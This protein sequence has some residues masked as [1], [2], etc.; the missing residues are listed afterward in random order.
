M[1][2]LDDGVKAR[3]T[4]CKVCAAVCPVR[5]IRFE[6]DEEGF[7]YPRIDGSKCV[8]CGKCRNVCPQSK[9]P[10]APLADRGGIYAAFSRSPGILENSTSG[11]AFT[12]ISDRILENGGIVFGHTYDGHLNCTCRSAE[13]KEGRGS[14]CGSKYV[15]SDMGTIYAEIGVQAE[16]GRPVLVTG[17]PCQADAVRQFFA[18]GIPENLFLLEI[19]CHGVP[20]PGIF[21]EYLSL[22]ERKKGKRVDGFTFRGKE[23]GWTTPLRKI[24]YEDGACCGELLNADAF[25][26]L[27]LGTDCILRPSCYGCRYAAKERVADISIGD[28]WGIESV[29]P[30]MFNGNKGCSL[31]LVNT[32]KGRRLFGEARKHMAV[33]RVAL[34][35]AA[36]RNLPLRGLSV[37]GIDREQFF[38]DYGR[39]G[40]ERSMRR[41]CF[42]AERTLKGRVKRLVK[43]AVGERNVARLKQILGRTKR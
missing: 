4:G 5:A 24:S 34:A 33:K 26:N 27:F 37:P 19:I 8:R 29:H 10:L 16:S 2:Y 12:H 11:G 28:F 39:I 38:L 14:F 1:T 20:S 43:S 32:E 35:D 17:T 30:D 40:L 9:A 22:I 6:S 13:T 15:Q 18:Q 21:R 31:V 3:C 41:H 7:W 36:P 25:N 42:K 23:V